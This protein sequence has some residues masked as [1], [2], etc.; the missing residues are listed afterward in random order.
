MVLKC[1]PRPG[2]RLEI[3]PPRRVVRGRLARR[4]VDPLYQWGFEELEDSK[5]FN[6]KNLDLGHVDS[7]LLA[8]LET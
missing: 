2:C 7:S 6:S 5:G 4:N 8:C 3:I 1:R